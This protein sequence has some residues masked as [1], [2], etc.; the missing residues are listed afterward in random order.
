MWPVA[1][2]IGENGALMF[3]YD[4]RKM[5]RHY[6]LPPEK[7]AAH[8]KKLTAIQEEVLKT[9]PKAAPA[10]DQFTRI[11]DLAIDYTEDVS[12]LSKAEVA[13]IVEI[14]KDHGATAKVSSIHV[15][16]WFGAYDKLSMCRWFCKN[17]LK[18]NFNQDQA[19][20]AFIGDSPNDEPMFA[21]FDNSFA[22]ANIREFVKDLESKPNYV[23]EA[24]AADGF[25]EFAQH[26]IKLQGRSGPA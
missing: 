14:F 9:I 1:G 21:A 3:R 23:T 16:G 17:V 13:K 26:L 6:V 15:N 4:G 19:H 22:V 8:R 2:V 24:K 5:H 25:V 11:F 7:M 18:I 20:I 12:R 10:S